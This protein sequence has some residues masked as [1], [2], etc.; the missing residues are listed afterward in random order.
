MVIV[1]WSFRRRPEAGRPQSRNTSVA[2]SFAEQRASAMPF[3]VRKL[4]FSL[5]FVVISGTLSSAMAQSNAKATGVNQD[6]LSQISQRMKSFID[7]SLVL[8]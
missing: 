4:L 8:A 7:S 6:V 5:L 1:P 2:P 3:P